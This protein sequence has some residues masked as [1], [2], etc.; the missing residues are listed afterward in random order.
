MKF[1][2]TSATEDHVPMPLVRRPRHRFL[3]PVQAL[4]APLP[5]LRV[6]RSCRTEPLHHWL[7]GTRNRMRTRPPIRSRDGTV[8]AT[9]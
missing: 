6:Q 7:R 2:S 3:V 5:A 1:N 9:P 4:V 8:H